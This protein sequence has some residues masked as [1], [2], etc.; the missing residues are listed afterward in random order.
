MLHNHPDLA[1]TPESPFIP[2]LWARRDR[3]DRHG[4]VDASGLTRDLMAQPRFAAWHVS[5]ETVWR[6][7][8]ALERPAFADVVR[9]AFRAFADNEGKPRWGNKTPSYVGQVPLLSEL[10]PDARFVHLLRDGRDVAP[11]LVARTWGPNTLPLAA[12][13]W[14]RQVRRGHRAGRDL[15]PARYLEVRYEALVADPED[16]LRAI[17]SFAGLAYHPDMLTRRATKAARG[18]RS[19]LGGDRGHVRLSEPPRP[20]VR[21]WRRD[22][23]PGEVAV[24]EAVAGPA[25]VEFGYPLSGRPIPAGARLRASGALMAATAKRSLRRGIR[26]LAPS[27][28]RTDGPA[29]DPPP[30]G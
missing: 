24:I 22:L 26:R 29:V 18:A 7:V 16:A 11:S 8:R 12:G 17:S 21:D 23:S 10:F 3:Y 9:A 5:E 13:Y 1:M 15:D 6:R 30:D 2:E 14:M 20:G 19:P 28:D 27:R 4:A 25:L